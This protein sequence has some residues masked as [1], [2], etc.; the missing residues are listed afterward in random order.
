MGQSAVSRIVR[1]EEVR[2]SRRGYVHQGTDKFKKVDDFWKK[3]IRETIYNFY[4]NRTDPTIYALYKKLK[5]ISIVTH[6]ELRYGIT[7]LYHFL[8]KL[9]FKYQKAD[10]RKVPMKTQ[11][12]VAWRWEYL[13]QFKKYRSDSYLK[14]YL[15]EICFDSHDTARMV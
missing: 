13:R 5:E 2:I 6:D 7:T 14:V 4:K 3:L 12:I 10:N 9:G 15:D 11:R 1:R 8:K